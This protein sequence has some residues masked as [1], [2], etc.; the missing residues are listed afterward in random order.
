MLIKCDPW[1]PCTEDIRTI[2]IHPSM[3]TVSMALLWGITTTVNPAISPTKL[4]R[5]SGGCLPSPVKSLRSTEPEGAVVNEP[6]QVGKR[7]CQTQ[8]PFLGK[9][10]DLL[11]GL[12]IFFQE[13]SL[14][15]SLASRYWPIFL[16]YVGVCV[17]HIYAFSGCG[18]SLLAVGL[19]V[20]KCEHRIR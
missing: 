1:S 20:H 9:F 14:V 8:A 15:L 3:N 11:S 6:S 18:L 2:S 7:W 10:W 19:C 13:N 16:I 4:T 12:N 17:D 5:L